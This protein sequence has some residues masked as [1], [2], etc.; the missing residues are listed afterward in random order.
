MSAVVNQLGKKFG[1]ATGKVL[2]SLLGRSVLAATAR[3]W[4]LGKRGMS[5]R[6]QWSSRAGAAGVERLGSIVRVC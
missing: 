4:G 1:S 2:L 3:C 5:G 6:R